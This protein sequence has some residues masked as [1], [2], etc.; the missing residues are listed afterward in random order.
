MPFFPHDHRLCVTGR[1]PP[2]YGSVLTTNTHGAVRFR[3]GLRVEPSLLLHRFFCSPLIV[4][5]ACSRKPYPQGKRMTSSNSN[6][7]YL[8]P[9]A[10]DPE[11]IIPTQTLLLHHLAS[12]APSSWPSS[13]YLFCSR[14]TGL[15]DFAVADNVAS[16]CVLSGLASAKWT[17]PPTEPCLVFY[18][19]ITPGQFWGAG[20]PALDPRVSFLAHR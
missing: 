20:S 13:S 8:L 19:P 12:R 3:G 11:V 10:Q 9:A 18:E 16:F 5:S 14:R 2:A 1:Q 15:G 4:P 6:T 7:T 17:Q